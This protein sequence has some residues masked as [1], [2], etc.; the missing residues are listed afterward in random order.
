MCR[1]ILTTPTCAQNCVRFYGFI[2]AIRN[3]ITI[4]KF[5]SFFCGR[6]DSSSFFLFM[7]TLLSGGLMFALRQRW[8]SYFMS[9]RPVKCEGSRRQRQ[10]RNE[11][12][13]PGRNRIIE[14]GV[15]R[16]LGRSSVAVCVIHVHRR[17]LRFSPAASMPR[18]RTSAWRTQC[19]CGCRYLRDKLYC[20][21]GRGG[22][23]YTTIT[24][25]VL[26]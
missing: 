1:P 13:F 15:G 23:L 2:S 14:E 3:K 24:C 10:E 11:E 4:K 16:R 12:K 9:T 18:P 19:I 5:E 26:Y 22:R 7:R 6:V 8:S 17:L 20:F 21:S 25:S